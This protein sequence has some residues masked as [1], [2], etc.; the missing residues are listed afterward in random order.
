MNGFLRVAQRNNV[1][2]ASRAGSYT[3]R[4]VAGQ[5]FLRLSQSAQIFGLGDGDAN[6]RRGRRRQYVLAG[7]RRRA[8]AGRPTGPVDANRGD[9]QPQRRPAD[10]LV[11]APR[12]AQRRLQRPHHVAHHGWDRRLSR[13]RGAHQHRRQ[14]VGDAIDRS[15]NPD[16]LDR[17]P[18]TPPAASGL[19]RTVPARAFATVK[20]MVYAD[21]NGNGLQDP[22]ENPVAGRAASDRGVGRVE[23]GKNGEF[24][25]RNVP[26]GMHDVG[27]DLGALPI[28]FDAP[29]FRECRWRSRGRTPRKWRSG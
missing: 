28:D 10:A 21:W 20:G 2:S 4:D 23:T 22:G 8:D 24:I 13:P 5:F 17:I 12:I 6:D 7:R 27:I 14:P 9:D 18:V 1:T 16:A 25:F 11:R 29:P 26:D 19:F 3:Q 15:P